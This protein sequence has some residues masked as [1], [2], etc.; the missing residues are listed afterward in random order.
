MM[1]VLSFAQITIHHDTVVYN[2]FPKGMGVKASYDSMTNTSSAPITITWYKSFDNLSANPG[3]TGVGL[4]DINACHV[5]NNT[6]RSF[7]I[8]PG[9]TEKFY[10]D[11]KADLGASDGPVYV[12]VTT[13][14]GDMVFKF[15]ADPTSVKDYTKNNL[16][17]DIYPN[18]ATNYVDLNI[19]DKNVASIHVL[20]V[21]GNRIAKFDIS[22]SI[23]NP[24][25]IPLN[26]VAE[27]V[28]LLQF[29]DANGRQLGTKR[30]IKK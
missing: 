24:V 30:L 16:V 29:S 4:C 14:F 3:W 13:N 23:P 27:G 1:S 20:N 12:V 18:P 15:N 19:Q 9:K 8:A 7:V 11:M 26:N 28:Y 2:G 5:Y 21:V 17:A 22:S 25:R 6:T 10:V